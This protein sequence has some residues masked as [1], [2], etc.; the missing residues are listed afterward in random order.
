MFM[1]V[2]FIYCKEFAYTPTTKTIADALDAIASVRY[3]NVQV[4]FIQSEQEDM[5]RENDVVT[6]LL[7]NLKWVSGK[8]QVKKVV[9]HSFAHLSDSKADP[10]FTRLLFNKVEE[11]LKNAGYQVSQTPFG[12]FLDLQ[13]DAPGFSLARVFKDL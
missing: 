10:D 3:E 9:L 1:K 12:Y 13:V 6:K 4:A 2:L 7:K 11:R 8:N 5:E